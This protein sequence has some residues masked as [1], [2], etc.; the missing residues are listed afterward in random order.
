MP[1]CQ[2][3]ETGRQSQSLDSRPGDG[4]EGGDALGETALLA[5]L[6]GDGVERGSRLSAERDDRLDVRL[7]AGRC[8]LRDANQTRR[9]WS[10]A[11][12]EDE[13]WAE[14]KQGKTVRTDLGRTT[15]P[16]PTSQERQTPAGV[17]PSF[18]AAE[19]TIG[20]ESSGAEVEL[21]RGRF[22][23]A[24]QQRDGQRPTSLNRITPG[25]YGEAR[26]RVSAVEEADV[27]RASRDLPVRLNDDAAFLAWKRSQGEGK[28]QSR[29]QSQRQ[30]MQRTVLDDLG[31]RKIGV[32]LDLMREDRTDR[33]A[34]VIWSAGQRKTISG[35]AD[36]A[37]G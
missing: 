6:G 19:R 21:Q 15:M 22:E 26:A 34:S 31:L 24:G 30:P 8:H 23:R 10:V 29:P 1:A 5:L 28:S 4:E 2:T 13:R 17:V 33:R 7:D 32:D 11:T 36:G 9:T 20:S 16:L 14:Q 18:S 3:A 35:R 27:D 12:I 37:P 25:D